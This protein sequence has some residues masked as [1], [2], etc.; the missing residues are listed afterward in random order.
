MLKTRVL[1]AV[2]IAPPILTLLFLLPNNI[3]QYLVLVALAVTGW[4]LLRIA[5]L[6]F[7]NQIIMLA[8]MAVVV[9]GLYAVLLLPVN[10]QW[11]IIQV[12]CLLWLAAFFWLAAIHFGR[13][14]RKRNMLLKIG[15][16]IL[17]VLPA[18]LVFC[19]LQAYSPWL[20]LSLLTLVWATDTFAFFVG[21][22]VGGPKLA[23]DISPNKTIAGVLGGIGGALLV[24]GIWIVIAD[25]SLWLLSASIVLA[26]ISVAGDLLAS[27][28]KRHAGRKD[29]SRLLPGH[30]GLLDRLDSLL[31]TAPFFAIMVHYWV[32]P[33]SA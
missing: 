13:T 33:L 11:S 8:T 28:L 30:G 24:S 29:S 15:I 6:N 31:P 10:V 22:A 17:F 19:L 20:V 5:G 12:A 27:L 26:L 21:R 2:C 14:Q 23:S 25:Q 16:S 4:E 7:T 32:L 1:L 18:M 9:A 3:W